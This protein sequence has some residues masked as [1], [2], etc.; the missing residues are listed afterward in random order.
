MGFISLGLAIGKF[1]Q[2]QT[3]KTKFGEVDWLQFV[4]LAKAYRRKTTTA[5]YKI[6]NKSFQLTWW[7][8][9]LISQI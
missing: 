4:V 2:T 1:D 8:K 3:A 7:N 5:A 6:N 9:I